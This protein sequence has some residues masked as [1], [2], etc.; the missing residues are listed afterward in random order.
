MFVVFY[1]TTSLLVIA[2]GFPVGTLLVFLSF[3]L[4][5]RVWRVYGLPKPRTSPIPNPVWPLW[6]APNAFLLTRRA[7]GLLVLG[8]VLGALWKF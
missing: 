7:G 4:L 1:V 3:P 2:G 8:F 6:F 5:V